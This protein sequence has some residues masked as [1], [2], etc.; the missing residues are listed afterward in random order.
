L[1]KL[2]IAA[3][4]PVLA[5]L[6]ACGGGG[7]GDEGNIRDLIAQGN[8]QDPKVCDRV[9]DRWL[10]Q[11]T[12]GDKKDCQRQ[13]KRSDSAKLKVNKVTVNGNSATVDATLRGKAGTV[14]LVKQGGDWK[15]D[16]VEQGS[17]SKSGTGTSGSG[18]EVNVK[19]TYDAFVTAAND[20]DETV[21]CGLMS[22]RYAAKLIH[23]TSARFPVAECLNRYKHFDFSR[24]QK[25][26]KQ[27]K[28]GKISIAGDTA[29]LQLSDGEH[30][31]FKKQ[32][33][34]WVIDDIGR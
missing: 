28:P 29:T 23:H 31:A 9:T 18:D 16:D 26:L 8:D 4:V 12:G 27:V 17:S 19:S 33:G 14:L 2:L 20:E 25:A 3:L 13:V 7:G 11:V 5:G 24:L 21:F 32:K 10:K 30:V 1:R 15:L 22:N 6:A 34:R